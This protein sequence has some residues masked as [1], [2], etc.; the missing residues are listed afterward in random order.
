MNINTI[1]NELAEKFGT[2]AQYLISEMQKYYIIE[3]SVSSF[4]GFIIILVS[5]FIM[6]KLITKGLH[7]KE[8]DGE[9]SDWEAPMIW[10]ILPGAFL[11]GSAIAFTVSIKDLLLW[12]FTPTAAVLHEIL[13]MLSK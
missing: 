1:I 10:S 5:A 13:Q 2:T 7:M 11:L 6:R 3:N 4:V 8:E 12:T 9:W